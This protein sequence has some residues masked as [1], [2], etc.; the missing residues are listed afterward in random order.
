M[1]GAAA[2]GEEA[3][4]RGAGGAMLY[5]AS[6]LHHPDTAV[7][8]P[9][10]WQAQGALETTRG[11]RGTVAF[12]RSSD[13][14]RWVLRHY[15]RGGLIAHV[16]DDLYVWTGADRTRALRE[17]RLLRQLRAWR[18][19]VPTP[20][21]ARYQRVGLFYRA[22]LIT[23]ELPVRR[24]L[25]QA[26]QQASLPIETW[27]AVGQCIGSLHARGVQHADLNAH[28]LLIGGSNDI[29][30]LDFD[31]GRIRA[32]GAWERAVLA[33]LQRSLRKVTTGLPAERFTEAHWQALLAGAGTG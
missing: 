25:T 18:L 21:A 3:L 28:N 20:V 8:D 17:W 13:G 10:H 33:R 2:A 16:S 26:L 5:D 24:T 22:D 1:N 30:V 31:R 19:P 15:R 32:R 4:A 14:Q 29:Y 27:H 12:V 7:F 6:C 11:G 23:A 9:A